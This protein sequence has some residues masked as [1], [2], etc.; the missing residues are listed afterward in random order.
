[1]FSTCTPPFLERTR[2]IP[3]VL[4]AV[5]LSALPHHEVRRWLPP[6]IYV[7][8]NEFTLLTLYL[9]YSCDETVA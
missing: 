2:H 1:M 4:R 8:G 5:I 3:H 7:E 9:K 6:K